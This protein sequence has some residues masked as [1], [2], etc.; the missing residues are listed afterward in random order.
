MSEILFIAHRMPFP[1]DRGD[2]I[3]SCNV[4]RRLARIAPVHVA[5]FAED[6]AEACEPRLA[7]LTASRCVVRRAKPLALAG[8]EAMVTR[9]PV[10]LTAFDSRRLSAYIARVLEE[11]PIETIYVFS[12]QMGQYVPADFK[13]RVVVD[14]VDV[15]S[16]KFAAYAKQGKGL[17]RWIDGREARLLRREEARLARRADVSLLISTEEASLFRARLGSQERARCDVQVLRN[18][19][20]TDV[21][22]PA[23][24]SEAPELAACPGPRLIFTGQMDYPPNTAAALRTIDKIMPLIRRR[25]PT[26]TFHVIGRSPPPYLKARH[27]DHGCYVWGK[28]DDMRPW[29]K[30][31]DLAMVALDIARGV[32]NKVLEAMAMAVPVVLTPQAATGIPAQD[33]EHWRLADS[34]DALAIA[35]ELLLMDPPRAAFMAECA[36]DF[37]HRHL[38]WEAA[39]APLGEIVGLSATRRD[40]A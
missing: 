14:F 2:K 30:G 1:P 34:D 20:D 15:D 21:F 39:L 3:R 11:R 35:A 16:A 24:V 12:G 18:G 22:N 4:L 40:A 5:T 29:F 37:V 19:I 25:F 31:A 33:G 36:R 9:A 23:M 17:R 38:S 27:G 10:S 6:E 8:A 7:Q 13:G 26:A 32:Q 28:V